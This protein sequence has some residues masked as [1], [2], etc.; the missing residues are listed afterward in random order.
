MSAKTLMTVEQFEQ[1][2]ETQKRYELVD[3]ELIELPGASL[4]HD[5]IRD[6]MVGLLNND[7]QQSA[8]GVAIA[9]HDFQT[10]PATVREPDA[11]FVLWSRLKPRD[12][13]R[14]VCPFAPDLAIEIVSPSETAL[15][16]RTKIHEYLDAGTDTVWVL[17]VETEEAEIWKNQNGQITQLRSEFLEA[18]C[19]P[20]FSVYVKLLF[21]LP[22]LSGE[23]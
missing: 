17:Y 7:S 10:T 13:R 14:N 3:G 9:R 2:G 21:A 4:L 6:N 22:E 12:L 19:L 1:M 15:E 11:A 8:R 16:L 5:Y 18:D 20:G 23:E